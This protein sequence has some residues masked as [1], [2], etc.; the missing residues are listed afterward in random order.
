VVLVVA[1]VLVRA[2][3][4]LVARLER[5]LLDEDKLA[6]R[7]SNRSRTL[8][9]VS[10]SVLNVV[11]WTFAL[12]QILGVLKIDLGPLIAGAGIAGVALGFGAQSLVRDF[13]T[14]FFVL[15]EDQYAVGDF[16]EIET[17]KGTVE[18]FNLRVTSLRAM[19]GTLHHISNGNIRMVGNSSAGWTKAIVDITVEFGED[20]DQ[21][22]RALA[23]AAEELKDHPDVGPLVLSSAEILGVET[24]ADGNLVMRVAIKTAPGMRMTVARAFRA[25]VKKVF[26][27]ESISVP[28]PHSILIQQPPPASAEPDVKT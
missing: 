8:A 11:V 15:L 12:L 21:V 20:L 19:D 10:R 27:E 1:N 22:E 14:G 9:E 26:A 16:I 3:R 25:R 18:R 24:I 7:G 6:G 17:A 2:G 4:R 5:R 28:T 13:L 23:R